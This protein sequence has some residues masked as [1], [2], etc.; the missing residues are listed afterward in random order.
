ME[1]DNKYTTISFCTFVVCA[2]AIAIAFAYFDKEKYES[3][4]LHKKNNKNENVALK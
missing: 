2:S 4:N 1:S 3:D